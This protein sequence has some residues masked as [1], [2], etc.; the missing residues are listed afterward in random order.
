MSRRARYSNSLSEDRQVTLKS[1]MQAAAPA[2]SASRDRTWGTSSFSSASAGFQQQ[3][4]RG[5]EQQYRID[6]KSYCEKCARA[7]RPRCRHAPRHRR[8]RRRPL[9]PPAG[10]YKAAWLDEV[11]SGD[12]LTGAFATL[13]RDALDAL[14]VD[15]DEPG[16]G[17][18]SMR[19]DDECYGHPDE[20]EFCGYQVRGHGD[21]APAFCQKYK[22]SAHRARQ[23]WMKLFRSYGTHYVDQLVLGGKM[24]F[25]KYIDEEA[26]N[27][28]KKAGVQ[29]AMRRAKDPV[30]TEGGGSVR[31]RRE[32]RLR[33]ARLR[34]KTPTRKPT[35]R[36]RSSSK[37]SRTR[38]RRRS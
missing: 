37:R 25:S 31:H 33:E 16:C 28:A 24:I 11:P 18:K 21:A 26:V 3:Q 19:V 10:R 14:K 30:G 22:D 23:L 2:A 32:G 38:R 9:P 20:M 7:R 36:S 13:A 35:R 15:N 34:S 5:F 8:R 1:S 17:E 4:H 6:V 27:K 29:V 12:Q